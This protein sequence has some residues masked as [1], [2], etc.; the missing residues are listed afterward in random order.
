ML[1]TL[2]TTP[3]RRDTALMSIGRGHARGRLGGEAR[4]CPCLDALGRGSTVV[5]VVPVYQCTAAWAFR[6]SRSEVAFPCCAVSHGATP[7]LLEQPAPPLPL[8]AHSGLSF[9]CVFYL[10]VSYLE[11][12]AG[13]HITRLSNCS[14]KACS[15]CG[16]LVIGVLIWFQSFC[17]ALLSRS[18]MTAVRKGGEL[19]T[20]AHWVCEVGSWI[21]ELNLCHRLNRNPKTGYKPGRLR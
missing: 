15:S 20:D 21:D 4:G 17:A 8:S 10:G 9:C 18:C 7:T 11:L 3:R 14:V 5:H 6:Q 13:L 16:P 19:Q 2:L 12:L 1:R